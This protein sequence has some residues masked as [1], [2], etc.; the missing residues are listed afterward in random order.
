[1][2]EHVLEPDLVVH[3]GLQ[4]LDAL[5]LHL[6]P[7]GVA[8]KKSKKILA[9]FQKPKGS[10]QTTFD[11]IILEDLV[12][13]EAVLLNLEPLN[14]NASFLQLLLFE[15]DFVINYVTTSLEGR[16]RLGNTLE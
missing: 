10:I 4:A 13:N 5:V 1:M 16:V 9:T 14:L 12:C 8:E 11:K 2:F 7:F 15:T 6:V 3:V